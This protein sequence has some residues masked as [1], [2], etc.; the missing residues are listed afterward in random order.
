MTTLYWIC[1]FGGLVFSVLAVFLGDL[2]DGVLDSLDGAFDSFDL[3][4]VLDPLS[5]VAA[6]TAF[7]G[8]GLL[9]DHYSGL[10]EPGGAF[11]ALILGLALGAAMHFVY[12]RPMKR[13]ENSTG[14]SIREYQGKIGEVNTAIPARGYGE[15]I[16]RMGA[17]V[18]FQ[19]AASFEGVPIATGTQVV[20]VEV[21]RDGT[22]LVAPLEDEMGGGLP[23]PS[24]ERPR[25]PE[26]SLT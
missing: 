13:S 1:L 10:G 12:I 11:L 7:G 24:V 4:S 25:L 23:L 9:L 26:R 20:V 6:L 22:L 17:A 15:V 3:S 19:S 16:V 2:L 8:A 5:L 18:T 21:E 14:F